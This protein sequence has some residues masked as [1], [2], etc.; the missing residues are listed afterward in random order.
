MDINDLTIGQARELA[1]IF[2]QG[3]VKSSIENHGLQI[4]VA[5]R[6]FVYI[7]EVTTDAEW[8]Y[9]KNASNIRVWGTTEGLG[10]LRNG[11]LS[12]TKLD[13][14]GN[15]KLNRK[16]LIALMEVKVDAWTSKL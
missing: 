10:Q 14:T 11:P 9:I 4:I 7:G 15:L 6:G 3:Q 12:T 8:V 13:K 2:S 5:D 1:N 16:A